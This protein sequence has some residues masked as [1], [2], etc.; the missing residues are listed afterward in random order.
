VQPFEQLGRAIFEAA[1]KERRATSLERT[2]GVSAPARKVLG[3]LE[4]R[5]FR[6]DARGH[7]SAF[8]R[9]A[10]RIPLSPGIP[11]DSLQWCADPVLGAAT[12]EDGG[13]FGALDAITF[14]ELVRDVE[15]LR[16]R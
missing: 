11:I 10:V 15:A 16:A 7:V 4:S 13:A 3:L 1:P 6:R 9:D 5:G 8:F 2:A 12:L 14:S